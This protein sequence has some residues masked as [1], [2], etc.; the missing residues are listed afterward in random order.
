MSF[1]GFEVQT[2]PLGEDALTVLHGEC[3]TVKFLEKASPS[4]HSTTPLHALVFP[5][6]KPSEKIS[7]VSYA[8]LMEPSTGNG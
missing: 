5:D 8:T 6:S 4:P 2:A 7:L 1:D 3:S